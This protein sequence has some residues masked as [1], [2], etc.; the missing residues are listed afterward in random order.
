[1]LSS[2]CCYILWI[3]LLTFIVIGTGK[4]VSKFK[5]WLDIDNILPNFKPSASIIEVFAYLAYETVQEVRETC[6][7]VFLK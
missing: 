6:Y 4:N 1:M 7:C 3:F 5:K 2:N